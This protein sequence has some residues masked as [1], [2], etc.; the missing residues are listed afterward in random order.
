MT[1]E[2]T[3]RMS[4]EI[5]EQP[6]ALRATF[7]V[8]LPRRGE[9]RERLAGR[10]H[11]LFAARGSSDNAAIYGRYLLETHAGIPAGLVSPSVAT[12]YRSHLDLSDAVVVA[13]SQSGRTREIVETLAWARDCGAVTV[14]VSND[15]SSDLATSS[16]LALTTV[17]GTELAVPATKSY[18]TQVAAMTV[19][20]TALGPDDTALDVALA[21]VPGQVE[22]VLAD[23]DRLEPVV[24]QL[25]DGLTVVTGRG[26]LM[27]TA[28]EIALKLEETC[29]RPVRGYSYADLRHGPI[30]AVQE[31]VTAVLVGA[32][33]GPLHDAMIELADDLRTRGATTVAVGGSPELSEACDLATGPLAV[34]ERLAPLVAVVPMQVVIE[35]LARRL[36]L[37]PDEPAGLSKVTRTDVSTQ[38]EA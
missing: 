17:A 9:I 11:V 15:E 36:G 29:A 22:A 2:A 10:R 3:T 4:Q 1:V 25:A 30:S 19:L 28:L 27:G 26:L 16:D 24:A 6:D 7:D 34:T 32:A 5:A 38:E 8:L 13:V 12:H 21:D 31:G 23:A 18:L 20:G 33:D 35:R 14:A 37:D